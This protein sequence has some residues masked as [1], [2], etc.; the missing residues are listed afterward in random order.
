MVIA[1][2]ADAD[3]QVPPLNAMDETEPRAGKNCSVQAVR[4]KRATFP[5]LKP[6]KEKSLRIP[7][8]RACLCPPAPL[9]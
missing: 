4:P 2:T 9:H 7:K 8:R 3:A 1:Q 5:T 6:V